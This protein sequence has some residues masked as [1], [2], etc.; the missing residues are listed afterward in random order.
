MFSSAMPVGCLAAPVGLYVVP[1]LPAGPKK[2]RKSERLNLAQSEI[3][4]TVRACSR[5]SWAIRVLSLVCRSASAAAVR[6]RQLRQ[7]LR[8]RQIVLRAAQVRRQIATQFLPPAFRGRVRLALPVD[9]LQQLLERRVIPP[10][11]QPPERVQPQQS[12][13]HVPNVLIE[14]FQQ[15]SELLVLSIVGNPIATVPRSRIP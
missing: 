6:P 4:R 5:F 14:H 7:K 2:T 9:V 8:Q 11:E 12:G 3:S 1:V 15:Q 10:D 13:L